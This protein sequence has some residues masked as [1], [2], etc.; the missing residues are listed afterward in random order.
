MVT[1]ALLADSVGLAL[2][3]VLDTGLQSPPG[4]R[5]ISN[6]YNVPDGPTTKTAVGLIPGADRA[7]SRAGLTHAGWQVCAPERHCSGN[8]TIRVEETEKTS[9]SPRT[10]GVVE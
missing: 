6:A 9:P 1:E 3:V 4:D 10:G 8:A 7:G 2:V 5:A